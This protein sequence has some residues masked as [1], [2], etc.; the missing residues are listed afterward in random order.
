MERPN[1]RR[2]GAKLK[3]C[4]HCGREYT[5]AGN[6]YQRKG[7][8]TCTVQCRSLYERQRVEAILGVDRPL[9]DVFYDRITCNICGASLR[10]I[11]KHMLSVHMLEVGKHLRRS[12]RQI[13]YGLT[14][15]QRCATSKELDFQRRRAVDMGLSAMGKQFATGASYP[16][17]RARA[18]K[19]LRQRSIHG[20]GFD[21]K[22]ARS[23]A[24]MS[25]EI[26]SRQAAT[27]FTC[28]GCGKQLSL[29]RS[30]TTGKKYCCKSCASTAANLRR[31]PE[32][33]RRIGLS[34]SRAKKK[35]EDRRC[36]GCGKS[37][38]PTSSKNVFCCRICFSSSDRAKRGGQRPQM[39]VAVQFGAEADGTHT[40]EK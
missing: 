17:H 13:L 36:L 5:P 29:P 24:R 38:S 40:D 6:W 3:K 34:I 39:I 20:R 10:A 19:S 14:Q 35:L 27:Q 7:Q 33:L 15:G 26:R 9:I 22:T 25:A 2:Q 16:P 1:L 21:G 30:R 4:I 23:L 32:L 18:N 8:I 31:G 37:F 11:G 28:L 12:E